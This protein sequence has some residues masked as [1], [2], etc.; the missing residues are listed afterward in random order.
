M[1]ILSDHSQ[2][3]GNENIGLISLGFKWYHGL[4]HDWHLNAVMLEGVH[5]FGVDIG[6]KFDWPAMRWQ[7]FSTK[8]IPAHIRS[9][10]RINENISDQIQHRNWR[11]SCI[12]IKFC[13]PIGDK[14][15]N[16]SKWSDNSNV[17]SSKSSFAFHIQQITLAKLLLLV[18][19]LWVDIM[20]KCFHSAN[21][22]EW[23]LK[24]RH[25]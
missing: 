8:Q 12:L 10:L 16:K 4:N 22:D 17:I 21:A 7:F 19:G 2:L 1:Q 3:K 23:L 25:V 11:G 20:L 18:R 15:D 14:W 9:T 24:W 6:S 5:D 13:Q